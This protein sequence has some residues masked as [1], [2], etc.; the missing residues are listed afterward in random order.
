MRETIDYHE[1]ELHELQSRTGYYATWESFAD[2]FKARNAMG[3][4]YP[5]TITEADVDMAIEIS[6]KVFSMRYFDNTNE[7]ELKTYLK[8]SSGAFVKDLV[9]YI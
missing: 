6:D 4:N 5:D 1:D 9:Q 7:T 3:T 2:N 8:A